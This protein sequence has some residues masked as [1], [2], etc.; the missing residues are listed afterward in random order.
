MIQ[1][2][3]EQQESTPRPTHSEGSATAT[4][5]RPI[6]TKP[7]VEQLPPYRVLLHNDPIT[8]MGFVITTLIELTPLNHDHAV[9][10][11]LE[12]HNTGV[13]LVLVTHK[14]RAE[15]YQEQFHSK[16]LMVTIEPAE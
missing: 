5:T 4:A 10:V 2:V 3:C 6:P 8:E 12:A 15:L 1:P 11:M 16:K 7:K 13:A 14:E 9:R